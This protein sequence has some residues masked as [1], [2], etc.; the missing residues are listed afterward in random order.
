LKEINEAIY[1]QKN[2]DLSEV[3]KEVL[4]S[5]DLL[6]QDIRKDPAVSANIRTEVFEIL[7]GLKD[8]DNIY[9][10][11]ASTRPKELEKALVDIDQPRFINR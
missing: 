4:S 8:F 5:Y 3:T 11:I 7:D 6:K 10:G 1:E 2:H 9:L